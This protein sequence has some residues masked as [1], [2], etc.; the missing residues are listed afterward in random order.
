M[1]RCVLAIARV[2]LFGGEL[3]TSW[4]RKC[5]REY[6]VLDSRPTDEF[7][8]RGALKTPPYGSLFSGLPTSRSLDLQRAYRRT[9]RGSERLLPRV[10]EA[11]QEWCLQEKRSEGCLTDS[12]VGRNWDAKGHSGPSRGDLAPQRG[13][14]FPCLDRNP[15]RIRIASFTCACAVKL[16]PC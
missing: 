11:S 5:A 15:P 6:G 1:H 4:A 2:K 10:Q 7:F 3:A 14:V 16:V 8:Q 12:F 13:I 9:G